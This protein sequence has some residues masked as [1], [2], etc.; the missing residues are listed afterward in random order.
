[1]LSLSLAYRSMP[2]S[3]RDFFASILAVT[4]SLCFVA[5]PRT[6]AVT[7]FV[8]SRTWSL[9]PSTE[10]RADSIPRKVSINDL[11]SVCILTNL[12]DHDVGRE[13][14][15]CL[16]NDSTARPVPLT[17]QASSARVGT[18]IC[19]VNCTRQDSGDDL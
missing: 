15:P 2:N 17:T 14:G 7:C 11:A 18:I 16:S 4:P 13:A 1:M 6:A 9:L 3:I 12:A 8:A 5:V 10:E 19:F